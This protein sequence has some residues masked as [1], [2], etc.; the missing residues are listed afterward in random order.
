M[1]AP[2]VTPKGTPRRETCELQNGFQRDM[3]SSAVL[4]RRVSRKRS[5]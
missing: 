3:E 5:I 1:V 2:I 4:S